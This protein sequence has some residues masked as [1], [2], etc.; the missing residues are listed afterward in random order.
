MFYFNLDKDNNVVPCDLEDLC[1]LYETDTGIDRRRVARD[2][3]N[4][5]DVS[6]VFLGADY[7]YG[8]TEKPLL[9]ETMIFS[10]GELDGYQTRCTT[11]DE[12]VK[13]HQEA[14]EIAK[15]DQS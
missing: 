5:Y 7:G 15:N 13:M 8:F 6:T 3:I 14:I 1:D 11:W 12:A 4:G 10:K 9:F 2:E